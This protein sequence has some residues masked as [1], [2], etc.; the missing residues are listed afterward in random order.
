MSGMDPSQIVWRPTADVIAASRLTRLLRKLQVPSLE[1]LHKRSVEEPEWYWDAV[2]RDLGLRWTQ[3]YT[4]VLDDSRGVMWP[5]WFE[6]GLLNF[7]DNCVDRHIDAGRGAHP[8]V[9]WEGDDGTTRT[10]TYAEL[11]RDVNRLANALSRLGVRKGDRVGIF[12][13][14][15][16]EAVMATLAVLRL[17]AIY[18]PCFSGFGAQA[19]V[20]RVQ[21]AEAKVLITADG[22]L[23]RGQIV[24]LKE[25]ADEAVAACPSV[26]HVLVLRRLGREIPWSAPR[27]QWWHECVAR[28]SDHCEAVAVEADHPALIIYT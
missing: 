12:L 22:F 24:K 1:A 7:T 4:R 25:T 14:M 5:R 21:D 3:P 13:P 28:E 6:G 11:A 18:T 26:K 2:V 16:P 20:S 10:L 8:A 19:V 9:V 23:R 15:S 27:D 17:G